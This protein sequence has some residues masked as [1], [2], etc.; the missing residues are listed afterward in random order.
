LGTI[1]AEERRNKSRAEFHFEA[2]LKL[3]PDF[4]RAEEVRQ[5]LLELTW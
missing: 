3:D 2:L 4:S 5:Q 1:Y